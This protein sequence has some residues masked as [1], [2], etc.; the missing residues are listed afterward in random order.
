MR[1]TKVLTH[2]SHLA[3]YMTCMSQNF[4]LFHVSNLSVVNFRIFA[5]MYPGW[6]MGAAALGSAELLLGIAR[7][8]A[9][10][11]GPAAAA[12]TG[13]LTRDGSQPSRR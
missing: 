5:L 7:P 11:A 4:R 13:W 8:A 3:V 12:G 9:R 6:V 1:Q 10:R 2:V